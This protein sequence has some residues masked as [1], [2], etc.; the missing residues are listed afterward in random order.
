MP[1]LFVNLFYI[2]YI[3]LYSISVAESFDFD[4]LII[5][6]IVIVYQDFSD[7]SIICDYLYFLCVVC[8]FI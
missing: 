3:V 2:I 8:L 6:S 7:V 1:I 5:K 4:N